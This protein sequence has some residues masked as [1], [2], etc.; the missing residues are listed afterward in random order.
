MLLKD[1]LGTDKESD[2]TDL[3]TA[4][5]QEDSRIRI[6]IEK[7]RQVQP[8]IIII[9]KDVSY[10]VLEKLRQEEFTVVTNLSLK[11]MQRIARFTQT[12]IAPSTNVL[13]RTFAIGKCKQFMVN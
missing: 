7:L 6:C 8:T 3:Q 13:D 1:S 4:L 5:D 12:I 2:L 9:E 11:K 10:K